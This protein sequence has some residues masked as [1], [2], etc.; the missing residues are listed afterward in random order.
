MS[1]VF[2]TSDLHL[3]HKSLCNG[4]RGMSAEESDGLIIEN[5]NKTVHKKDVVYI[6][7]DITMEKHYDIAKMMSSL[8]GAKYIIGGNHDTMRCCKEYMRLGIPMLGCLNYKG[9][10][11]T[12][13]PIHPR[14][15]DFCRGNI[16]GHIHLGGDIAGYGRYAP[17]ALGNG[18]Y[19]VN[20]EMHGYNPVLFDEIEQYF[21]NLKS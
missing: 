5:W 21:I 1:R 11:C 8:R 9:F 2:F 13:I 7:G 14:E 15:L 19:N 6:L 4:L 12:H 20:T 17:Y 16:H 18:Y 10:F 3:G